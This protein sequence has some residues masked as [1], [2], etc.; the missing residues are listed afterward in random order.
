MITLNQ[1]CLWLRKWNKNSIKF[2][3]TYNNNNEQ[4]DFGLIILLNL[5]LLFNILLLLL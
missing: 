5:L 1:N 2:I 3:N 4:K